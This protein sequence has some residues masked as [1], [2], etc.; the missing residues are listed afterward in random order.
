MWAVAISIFSTDLFS[1]DRTSK[2]LLPF[3]RWL[4]PWVTWETTYSFLVYIRRF[5]HFGEYFVF[6]ALVFRGFRG[7]GQ[8]WSLAWS[9]WTVALVVGYSALDEVH[10][11]FVPSRTGSVKDVLID[12]AGSVTAQALIWLWFRRRKSGG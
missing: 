9:F 2:V 7:A 12:T 10:Q 5:A 8:G 1:A 11:T 4:V 3:L 6:S